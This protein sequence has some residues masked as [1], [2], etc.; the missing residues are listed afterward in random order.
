MKVL[1]FT[2]VIFPDL[3]VALN[4]NKTVV[5]GW[6]YSLAKE[7][8]LTELELHVVATSPDLND[9]NKPINQINYHVLNSNKSILHYDVSLEDKFKRLVNEVKPDVIHI[10]GTEHAHGLALMRACPNENFVVSIQG[11]LSVIAKHYLGGIGFWD[12]LKTITF[13]DLIKRDS[14]WQQQRKFAK[15]G[16]LEKEYIQRTKHVLGRTSWDFAH[17]KAINPKSNYHAA[18]RTFRESFYT[19]PKWNNKQINQYSIFLS[20]AGY[21][22]KG[23]HKVLEAVS[24]LKEEFPAISIRVGGNNIIANASFKEKLSIRGY[25][26][27][28]KTLLKKYKLE[29]NITFLG[30][31]DED[32][33]VQEYT[34][35]HVFICPSSIE[36]SPNSLGE[37]QLLGVPSISAYVGGVADMV[38]DG[39]TGLL[40][41][42]EE[43]EMLV[44]LIRKIFIDNDFAVVLSTKGIV[45]AKKRHETKQVTTDMINIYNSIIHL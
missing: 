17:S 22:I 40:Y 14:L 7:L 32:K 1:W 43:V 2:Q 5:G 12:I 33:M 16:I 19:S 6:T 20:Q 21:P 9:F 27:Y 44:Q 38:E 11:L 37:A 39:E 15:R 23:L 31:L 35:A 28:I 18:N 10:H 13:R 29:Q 42:Y 36:N 41:R 4:I 45:A 3:S 24:L 30:R 26:K 25:G 34:S 8:V